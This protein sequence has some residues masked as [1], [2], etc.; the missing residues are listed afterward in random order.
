MR[1]MSLVLEF[2]RYA[3]FYATRG[4]MGWTVC[5]GWI[6][7]SFWKVE[8]HKAMTFLLRSKTNAVSDSASHFS[9]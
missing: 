1:N 3:G 5:L 7:L 9:E 4:E 8:I 2:G 6:A